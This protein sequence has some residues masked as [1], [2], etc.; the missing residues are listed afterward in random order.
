LAYAFAVAAS[1]SDLAAEE[2][3]RYLGRRE[4]G[5][6]IDGEQLT[7]WYTTESVPLLDGQPL[8]P[9]QKPLRWLIDRR[10]PL[11]ETP[12]SYVEFSNGDRVGGI[13]RGYRARPDDVLSPP[14]EQLRIQIATTALPARSDERYVELRR[15]RRIAWQRRRVDRYEPGHVFLRQGVRLAFRSYRF[16]AQSVVFLLHDGAQEIAFD[17]MAELHF[18]ASSPWIDYLDEVTQFGASAR[19]RLMQIETTRGWRIT[20]ST[21]RFAARARGDR[22]DINRWMH[23]LQ[24]VWSDQ[25]IWVPHAVIRNRRWWPAAIVPLTRLLPAGMTRLTTART[26]AVTTKHYWPWQTDRDPLIPP[27]RA[28]QSEFGWGLIGYD[29]HLNCELPPMARSIRVDVGL[30]KD[31]PTDSE[32]RAAIK[33][34]LETIAIS[35]ALTVNDEPT[36][37]SVR[38]PTEPADEPATLTLAVWHS[39]TRDASGAGSVVWG[40]P[41]VELDAEQL[42][43]RCRQLIVEAIPAWSGWQLVSPS[44]DLRIANL[45]DEW[46]AGAVRHHVGISPS[47]SALRLV[48]RFSLT[49]KDRW[50]AIHVWQ[51]PGAAAGKLDVIVDDERIERIEVPIS[52]HGGRDIDPLVV[53]LAPY[54]SHQAGSSEIEIEIRQRPEP[55]AAVSWLGLKVTDQHPML[56][57]VEAESGPWAIRETP[58]PG[59]FRL[60]RFSVRRLSGDGLMFLR[61][62]FSDPEATVS[63]V[64]GTDQTTEPTT[65]QVLRDV[66]PNEWTTITRD[67]YADFGSRELKTVRLET[68]GTLKVEI[69]PVLLA[70]RQSGLSLD[71]S[72][73]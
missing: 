52:R 32:S 46:A 48:R 4:N 68:N 63:Y 33:K 70:R 58:R 59:Q 37:L 2:P 40:D 10:L 22:A 36:E 8:D 30:A 67:V 11:P 25:P 57:V 28:A 61:L 9:A 20:T 55:S 42:Q 27:L 39:S 50:L 41:Q 72:S 19:L 1:Y 26:G 14:R 3:L 49:R 29:G 13:V 24:P 31:G 64:A 21:E 62:D 43:A 60:L 15:V 66:I 38:W 71:I 35:P 45:A 56:N 69:T 54:F 34:R 51:R 16:N 65:R 53:P 73:Q 5:A 47:Q 44:S 6:W 12:A 23:G 7:D 17:Q 18:P